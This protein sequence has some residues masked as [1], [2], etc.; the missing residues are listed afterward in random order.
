MWFIPRRCRHSGSVEWLDIVIND[1]TCRPHLSKNI[2]FLIFDNRLT[3]TSHVSNICKKLS[4]YLHLVGFHKRV[5][6]V[7]LIKLLTDSLVLLYNAVCTASLGSIFVP[8]VFAMFAKTSEPCS[9][10][11]IFIK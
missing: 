7:S 9:M 11:N 5:L 3:W 10:L 8:P 1:M 6:P 2:L 4:Y